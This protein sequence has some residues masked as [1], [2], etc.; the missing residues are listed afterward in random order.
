MVAKLQINLTEVFA[1][2]ELIKEIIDL[3]NWVLVPD[4]DFI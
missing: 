3:G 1:P 4:C 2:L